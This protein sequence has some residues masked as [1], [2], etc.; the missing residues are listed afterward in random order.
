M[1]AWLER[2]DSSMPFQV[3][4]A[5]EGHEIVQVVNA[6]GDRCIGVAKEFW[7]G[8]EEDMGELADGVIVKT[9]RLCT[10]KSTKLPTR[11]GG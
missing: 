10:P 7:W 2:R 11:E 6:R 3:W 8:Y 4:R 5:F 9:R 1:G